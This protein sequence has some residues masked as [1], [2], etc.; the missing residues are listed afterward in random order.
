MKALLISTV[1]LLMAG[2][3][4]CEE[5]K[6]PT[7]S[8]E[9]RNAKA[10]AGG[11]AAIVLDFVLTNLTD[12]PI[13]LAERWNSWGADQWRFTLTDQ[14]GGK[15]ELCNSQNTWDC[16]FLS[17]FTIAAGGSHTLRCVLNG[18]YVSTAD[19]DL[20]QFL[21][22]QNHIMFDMVSRKQV[23]IKITWNYPVK[24]VGHFSAPL[25][26]R[27][28]RVS[29]N[30][31]GAVLTPAVNIEEAEP[32]HGKPIEAP[33]QPISPNKDQQSS[34]ASSAVEPR[35]PPHSDP[36]RTPYA[37]ST[38]DPKYAFA[39]PSDGYFH[40]YLLVRDSD[41]MP[42]PED[43]IRLLQAANSYFQEVKSRFPNWKAELVNA[44][45]QK[46]QDAIAELSIPDDRSKQD[47]EQPG[48]A[49]PATQPA[50]KDPVKDQPPTPT[51]KDAPR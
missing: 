11:T 7:L 38:F 40:G 10:I 8:A 4:H 16:N 18:S 12:K 9:L 32:E 14:S 5:P 46:T 27:S 19:A 37:A 43:S 31:T 2:F 25:V 22:P 1:P 20:N 29:T 51:S 21:P 30:W 15:I 39:D 3:S 36:S 34:Q 6:S 47:A 28:Q 33:Q 17:T 13:L 50:D 41:R 45:I 26:N 49:Q 23:P 35:P 44:R 24:V 42:R 48:P